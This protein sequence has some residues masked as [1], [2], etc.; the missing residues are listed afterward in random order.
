M[1]RKHHKIILSSLVVIGSGVLTMD[2]LPPVA[3]S[4]AVPLPPA[5]SSTVRSSSVRPPAAPAPVLRSA[6]LVGVSANVTDST[7]AR[8]AVITDDLVTVLIEYG[9]TTAYG[10]TS[11]VDAVPSD[12]HLLELTQLVP[13]TTYQYRVRAT[14]AAGNTIYSNNYSFMTASE[15]GGQRYPIP[16][17]IDDVSVTA[18]D[19]TSVTLSWN[20]S[21]AAADDSAVYDIRYGVGPTSNIAFAGMTPAQAGPIVQVTL[22]PLGTQRTYVVAGLDPGQTYVFALKSR[23]EQSNWSRISN[24][25]FFTLPFASLPPAPPIA[26]PT[27]VR[28][29]S[30]DEQNILAWK[31][32]SS[33]T[34]VR[35]ILLRKTDGFSTSPTDG[36]VLYEGDGDTYTDVPI[37]NWIKVY[38]TLYSYDRTGTYSA[39]LQ[40]ARTP[41]HLIREVIVPAT[42]A[43]VR[44]AAPSS[45]PTSTVPAK[46]KK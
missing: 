22:H 42:S 7:T 11:P 44:P 43:P 32:P 23:S 17:V 29:I 40:V 21:D 2:A 25:P 8:V 26:A 16:D 33:P 35:T 45:S 9:I 19:A 39:P 12:S 30:A 3:P 37:T 15:L 38:Y 4:P 1:N 13:E 46:W 31:N 18:L 14:D 41:D 20:V 36:Q 27:L 34:F 28:A 5:L 6:H 10:L 24:T